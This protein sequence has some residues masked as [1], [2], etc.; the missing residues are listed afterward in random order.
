MSLDRNQLAERIEQAANAHFEGSRLTEL[1]GT[2]F[3]PITK[4]IK[5]V[6]GDLGK[7][8]CF[9]VAA[10]GYPGADEGE[11][12][13]DMLWNESADGV[14]TRQAMVLESE[15]KPGGSVL[16]SAEV[17]GDFQKLVQARSDVRVWLALLPTQDLAVRHIAN[18]KRQAKLFE[19][20]MPEDTYVF[21]VYVWQTKR[22]QCSV[23]R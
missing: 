20:A 4:V 5:S 7:S 19:G 3:M 9:R 2:G 6:F 17:E 18:C 22:L 15:L 16:S 21:V 8:R 10:A 11:W 13:Y 23:F 14:M 1:L 12:L